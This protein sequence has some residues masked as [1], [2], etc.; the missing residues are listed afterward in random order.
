MYDPV[1]PLSRTN[2][3]QA[4]VRDAATGDAF[5]RLTL[6]APAGDADVEREKIVARPVEIRSERQIQVTYSGK[7]KSE[8]KNFAGREWSRQLDELLARPFTQI[9]VQTGDG[10]LHIRITR[11]GRVLISK[12]APSVAGPA[13]AAPHNRTKEYPLPAEGPDA[14][15]EAVGI[16]NERGEV[17]PSMQAKFR[18][19]NSFISLI[20]PL[21]VRSASDEPLVSANPARPLE[22]LDCGC[23]SAY[24]TFALYHVLA[25]SRKIRANLTGID[26]NRDVIEKC[27][28]LRDKLGWKDLSFG[29]ADIAGFAP[30]T[31]PDLVLSLHA[32][33]TATDE[34]IAKGILSNS[35][36]IV[37]AP[38]CQ[39]ELHHKIQSP[40]F[41]AVL[42]HGILRERLADILTDT[43]R[44]LALTIM[45]YRTQV[46]EFVSADA[47][48][49]NLL[50]RAEKKQ[51]PG[52]ADAAREYAELKNFW[53]VEPA[54]EGLLGDAFR[55]HLA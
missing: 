45:G 2:N 15:L 24:L 41:S 55:R 9:H 50:I 7:G 20:E 47:T 25:H 16:K 51:D 27:S 29:V 37:A 13:Q 5:R 42:H 14:F 53:S 46:V 35:R 54:I 31:P 12:G 49:K 26:R 30:A 11:K 28:A 8:V 43:F 3:W 33:D 23:G 17:R 38:C 36:A 52:N 10:D 6:S 22:I 32:C 40:H 4:M 1:M 21:V 39:H 34:A 44:A 48:P 18:Q 19:I